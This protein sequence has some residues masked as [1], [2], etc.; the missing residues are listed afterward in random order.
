MKGRREE[1]TF[2]RGA[3]LTVF[4]FEFGTWKG[5]KRKKRA[6]DFLC[7]EEG[8]IVRRENRLM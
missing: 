5:K 6:R 3:D 4:E 1:E 8:P 2:P 7:A